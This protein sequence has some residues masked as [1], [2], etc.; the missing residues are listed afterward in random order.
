MAPRLRYRAGPKAMAVLRREGLRPGQIRTLVGPA[1]GPRWLVLEAI[2]RVLLESGWL[3][4]GRIL[5]AGSSAGSWRMLSYASADP[6]ATHRRLLEGYVGQIFPRGT[7]PT[8]VSEA[9]RSL[10]GDLYADQAETLLHHPTFD[11]A[12][13]TVRQRFGRSGVAFRASLLLSILLSPFLRQAGDLF[14]ERVTFLSRPEEAP[15]DLGQAVALNSSNLIEAA[16]AS[17][18]VPI[19]MAPVLDPPGAPRGAYYDGGFLDYYLRQAWPTGESEIV[20]MPHYQEALH[21]RWLDRF[22]PWSRKPQQQ[23]MDSL[24]LVH[25]SREFLQSLP[26]GRPPDRDDFVEFADQPEERIRRWREALQLCQA[27]GEEFRQDL[28]GGWIAERVETL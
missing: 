1:S 12:L 28:E 17:G 13:H 21:P 18:T 14:F 16:L 19:Y 6:L 27:L 8:V 24:L 5:L 3:A 2:D 23:A 9:Y 10:L 25:P 15:P 22:L 26:G 20:L 4:P 7:S 11:L